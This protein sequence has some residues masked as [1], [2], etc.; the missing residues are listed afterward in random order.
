MLAEKKKQPVEVVSSW[1]T[2]KINF[3]LMRSVVMCVKGSR[4]YKN[5]DELHISSLTSDEHSGEK[6][7]VGF[8]A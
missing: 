4:S 5:L 8:N 6:L 7:I 2:R 1:L 3:S